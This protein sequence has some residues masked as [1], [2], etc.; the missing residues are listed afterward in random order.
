MLDPRRPRRAPPPG[1]A[2]AR[3]RRRP[4]PARARRP[5]RDPDRGLRARGGGKLRRLTWRARQGPPDLSEEA[6]PSG[7]RGTELV[8]RGAEIDPPGPHLAPRR[9]PLRPRRPARG[10]PGHQH[11]PAQLPRQRDASPS[12]RAAPPPPRPRRRRRPRRAGPRVAAARR[13]R[14]DPPRPVLGPLL[15]RDRRAR[16]QHGPVQ[17]T[18]ADL[19][20]AVNPHVGALADLGVGLLMHIAKPPPRDRAP[21]TR[22]ASSP[23]SCRPCAPAAACA[24]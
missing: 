11:R 14:R 9:R 20:A 19:R 13:R 2:R 22:P 10:R 8:L 21:A 6:D 15:R 23:C 12:A 16:H 7:P 4:R 24:S 17:A 18:A 1:P 3:G 5:R